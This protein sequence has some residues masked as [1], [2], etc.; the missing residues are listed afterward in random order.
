MKTKVVL[1][2][3]FLNTTILAQ[4]NISRLQYWFD[5][6][7]TNNYIINTN[8][9]SI[10]F[11]DSIDISSLPYGFHILNFR[12]S[13]NSGKW[14]SV[15]NKQFLKINKFNNN[16]NTLQYW[17][18]QNHNNAININY[19][20]NQILFLDSLTV[21]AIS[22]GL[23][24]LHFKVKDN[25]GFWSS[26]SSMPFFK[27]SKIK[28][29]LIKIAYWIDNQYNNANIAHLNSAQIVF[30]DSIDI[31]ALNKGFHTLNVQ[32]IDASNNRSS[33][34]SYLFYKTEYINNKTISKLEYWFD[35]NY[36]NAQII[37][38]GTSQVVFFDSL[39]TSSLTSG[40]HVLNIRA[41][42]NNLMTSSIINK[43]F[44]KLPYIID[45]KL[46]L[47]EYWLNSNSQQAIQIPVHSQQIVFLDSLN[48]QNIPTGMHVLNLRFKDETAQWSSIINKYFFKCEPLYGNTITQL[49]Y[50]FDYDYNQRIAID[51][52]SAQ[53]IF[54]DSLNVSNLYTGMHVISFRTKDA[55]GKWS[56]VLNK[57]FYKL[58][59][60]YNNKITQIQYWINNDF[61][62]AT[63]QY[64]NNSELIFLDS[65]DFSALPENMYVLNFR[66]KDITG[67]WSS[68]TN[69]YFYKVNY[70]SNQL[71]TYQYWFN[72][73]YNNNVT[74][75]T[76][77]NQIV[78]IDS[79]SMVSLNVGMHNINFRFKDQYNNWSSV[80]TKYIYKPPVFDNKIT[81]YR[82]WFNHDDLNNYYS[83]ITTPELQ[84]I[85]IDS[86]SMLHLN[87][88][89]YKIH[90]QFKDIYGNWST[91]TT[92]TINKQPIAYSV[93]NYN[94]FQHC[95]STVIVFTNNS[96]D[97]QKYLWDFGDGI[98]DSTTNPT[99]TYYTPGLYTITLTAIDTLFGNNHTTSQ[100]IQINIST[101]IYYDTTLTV[102]DGYY[103]NGYYYNT[104]GT[105]V[106]TFPQN[107]CDSTVTL[108]LTVTHINYDTTLTV[109][110]GY[111]WNGYYYNTSG[112]YVQTLSS[113]GCDS[114][115]TLHLT[116]NQTPSV[117]LGND[118]ILC[119]NYGET[120]IILNA[121]YVQ[122]YLWS[123]GDTTS[124]LNFDTSMTSLDTNYI[125]VRVNNENCF[126][127]DTIM[128]I[129]TICNEILSNHHNTPEIYP[130]PFYD[131]LFIVMF[132]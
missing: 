90:F 14:S 125:W 69:K 37:N 51:T 73:D 10:A 43:Y 47:L 88:G 110:D 84:Y 111:Y 71:T 101:H 48:V 39:L 128:V 53:L 49:E 106:Q 126:A 129:F 15:S 63:T 46:K 113:N 122:H 9:P 11:N 20:N 98:I 75:T 118:T 22:N 50:W 67:K 123:T 57:Y 72:N 24:W 3:L 26:I 121:G 97:A 93:F 30:L 70:Y 99:H 45:N 44:Y 96:V 21:T 76:S 120:S 40:M 83:E 130:N 105:Y 117:F 23:H 100:Q 92:D 112:T 34:A 17:F 32:F 8:Q 114:T 102:C 41:I 116:V 52:I 77:G 62:N 80:I 65:I 42:D 55:C 124:I 89:N 68:V 127:S 107:G 2:F 94:I 119:L 5:Y 79:L 28:N 7:Y 87:A 4:N 74:G 1:I 81:A 58:E 27:T 60:L 61:F 18:D 82:Y 6:N 38:V 104:S 33:V 64:T 78:F 91:I 109:C 86:I 66:T 103:W 115:V 108:H 59:P 31:N 13:D 16:I 19:N 132:G 95:D 36:A 12:V 54:I 25:H 85:L 35:N 29:K 131:N 56:S